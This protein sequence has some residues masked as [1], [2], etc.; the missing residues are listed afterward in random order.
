MANFF[1]NK[2]DIDGPAAR[3]AG[4]EAGHISRVLRMRAGEELTLC[5][6]EGTFYDAV[7]TDIGRD[8][9]LTKIGRAYPAPTEPGVS[10]TLFQGIPKNPKLEFIVQKA[11]EL[12]VTR[13]VPVNTARIVARLEKESKVQRL[14]KI[15]AEAARQSRRGII[16]QVCAPVSFDKALEL[17]GEL[18]LSII[19]Y[20]EEAGL[21]AKAFLRGKSA[22]TLGIFIGPEGGFE[23]SEAELAANRGVVPITLGPRILRTE[24]AGLVAAALA[25]YELGEME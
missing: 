16:P 7:I 2:S 24:T 9:V 3:I 17:A 15:A 13:I 5:D 23:P 22:E 8:E 4:E 10:I 20:E 11:T 19:P 18:D 25:L 1:V 14:Q 21:S 6:G 12:G